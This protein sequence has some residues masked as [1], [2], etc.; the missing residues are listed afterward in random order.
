MDAC[1]PESPLRLERSLASTD[2]WLAAVNGDWNNG[3]DWSGGAPPTAA[4]A[5]AIVAPGTYLVTLFGGAT[6]ASVTLNAAGAEFYDAGGL[7][8]G[9]SFALQAGTLA[10]AAGALTGGTLALSGGTLLAED[11][12]LNGVTVDGTLNLGASESS[13]FVQGGLTLSGAGGSGAGSIA[14]TSAY[15]ALDFLGSQTLNN[16]T[17]SLGAGG[18]QPGQTGPATLGITHQGGAT[19]GATLTLGK[20]LWIRDNGGQGALTVGSAGPG[21]GNALA[22]LLVSQG[23]ITVSGAGSVLTVSGSGTF[24]NQGTIGVS[25]GATLSLAAAGLV[26]TGG[27]TVADATL[28][29]GGTFASSLLSSLGS[30]TLSSGQV[31]IDGTADLDGGTLSLGGGSAI[32][33]SLGALSL[34][35]TLAGGTILDTGGGLTFA[36]SGGVFDDVSYVGALSLAAAG[37]S[38]VM[39]DGSEVAAA[40]G[41][42]GSIAVTGA[43]ASLLL[44]GSETLDDAMIT[45]GSAGTAAILGTSDA[46][47]AGST[48]TATLGAHL[49]LQQTG[50]DALLEASNESGVQGFGPADTL[51]NQGSI[52]AALPGGSFGISGAGTFINQGEI[53]VSGGDV[54]SVTAAAFANAGTLTAGAGGILQL[55]LPASYFGPSPAWSNQGQIIVAGGTLVMN[56]AVTTGQLG[57]ITETQ[58]AGG[59]IQLAGT[60]SNEGATLSLGTGGAPG[61]SVPALSLT[62]TIDGGTIADP[63]GLLAAGTAEGALL[64]GTAYQGTLALTQADAFLR[65]RNGLTLTGTASLLGPGSVLDFQGSQTFS[66]SMVRLGAGASPASM[67]LTHDSGA[68]GGSTLTLSAGTTI[69]QAGALAAIGTGSSVAGDAV[70]SAATIG[71]GIAGGT[72]TLGGPDFI[73]QGRISVSNGDTLSID[74]GGFTNSG[75]VTA[76]NA[77]VSLAGNLT[78][79]GLGNLTLTNSVMAVTGDLNL[80]TGTLA[81]GLG[82]A[83]GRLSL[84]GTLT[85]GSIADSGAGLGCSAGATLDDVTYAGLLDLSRPFA[86][87]DI[88][89]GITLTG[90][91]GSGAGSIFLTGAAARLI[92]SGSETI[93]NAQIS[94]GSVSQT[95]QGQRLAA[96]ELAAA[97]A[98]QLTLGP[99]ATVTLAGSFGLLGDAG[100]GQ[101]TDS[102]VSAGQ[103][104]AASA[105]GTL[106]LGSSLFTNTGT[107]SASAGGVLTIADAGFT[108]AGTIDVGAGSAVQVSLYDFYADPNA[109]LSVLTNAGTI[110]MLGGIF[111][112]VTANGLFPS[113]PIVNLPGAALTGRGMVFA[114]LQN[115][116]TVA[117]AGGALVLEQAISGNGTLLIDPGGTLELA[118]G[119]SAGQ[120]ATFA[121]ATGTLRLDKPSAFA[122]TISQFSTGDVID[123]PSQVLTGVGLSNGTLV[124]STA[125]QNYRLPPSAP[126]AGALSSGRDAHGGATIT[127][128]P[129]TVGSGAPPATLP[130]PQ[131]GMLFWASPAGDVFQGATANLNGAHI[132]NWSAADSIDLL[133]LAISGAA[134]TVTQT[135]GL[136]TLH[137]TDGTHT[138]SIG[139][140]GTFSAANF[141]LASDGATGT[142]LTYGNHG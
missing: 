107:A 121:G 112:E 35:G 73:N 45:L 53:T 65:I 136:S 100:L 2:S 6:A 52:T 49:L 71:A 142:V 119:A 29:L 64:D 77:V 128:T 39:T 36:P 26:N 94:L 61:F 50:S 3:A 83:I 55:G 54:L 21:P 41:G 85:G 14:L 131:S 8:L 66:A 59:A 130:V 97:A 118:A 47:L 82:T 141:H 134:L 13:L 34:A 103:I 72:L 22:D 56:G 117:A 129:Q 30:V 81:I 93:D 63:G 102:I 16:A 4:Q 120:T 89:G 79:A 48:T 95:Y 108:N 114:Q 32:T 1:R 51:V 111:Q 84:T 96:P 33:G 60:L 75:S 69:T 113:V 23:T 42:A 5:A 44:R 19:S 70:V 27:I 125:T 37:A 90:K 18:N 139:L 12:T 86:Q 87:L 7:A 78:L 126:L 109:G 135:P 25:G 46:W 11:G 101:W 127:I 24:D 76:A 133:D 116:G 140:T 110:A 20:T 104:L 31:Q 115:A 10:L 43:G 68:S 138:A 67:E 88:G 80:G 124:A 132:S 137:L 28:A 74:A 15:A 38:L 92:A 122:G 9:G 99:H 62:G 58:G 106:T 57:S 123:L 105:G 17:V 91:G 98:S 40:G